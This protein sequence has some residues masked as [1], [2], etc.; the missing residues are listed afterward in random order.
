MC[1]GTT[2]HHSSGHCAP[3]VSG[4]HHAA[5]CACGCGGPVHFGRR[6]VT[7]EEQAAWLE[8]YRESLQEEAQA[9]EERIAALK[10]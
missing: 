6:F 9:V 1:C 3:R 4:H 10:E 7:K 8:R 5:L 2:G